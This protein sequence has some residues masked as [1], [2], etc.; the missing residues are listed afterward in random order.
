MTGSRRRG[1][2]PAGRGGREARGL[3]ETAPSRSAIV[4]RHP[5]R[6]ATA[7]AQQAQSNAGSVNVQ[8][9]QRKISGVLPVRIDVPRAGQ[10][11]MFVRPV[12]IDEDTTVR[13]TYR[14]RS[15]SGVAGYRGVSGAGGV[16][17]GSVDTTRVRIARS[18]GS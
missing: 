15:Y 16:G 12:V 10:S 6:L 14:A 9:L 13:F 2:P 11:H 18:F 17:A 7:P 1:A 4:T 5:R 8:N 3:Y